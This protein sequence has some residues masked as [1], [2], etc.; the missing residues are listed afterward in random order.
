M[1][2]HYMSPAMMHWKEYITFMNSL[3][4]MYNPMEQ[5]GNMWQIQMEGLSMY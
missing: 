4:K 1:H 3:P 5:L 2:Q